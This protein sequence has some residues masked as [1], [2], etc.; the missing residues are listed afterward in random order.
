MLATALTIGSFVVVIALIVGS[1]LGWV[2]REYMYNYHDND[3][4]SYTMHPEMYDEDGNI[5][6]D[7]LIAFRFENSED[8]DDYHDE[9]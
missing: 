1:M 7:Q 8:D 4:S 2:A 5:L 3:N 9:D 6:A